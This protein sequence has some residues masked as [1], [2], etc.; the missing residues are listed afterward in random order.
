MQ[1]RRGSVGIGPR[2]ISHLANLG[3]EAERTGHQNHLSLF[4]TPD[5]TLEPTSFP[6]LKCEWCWNAQLARNQRFESNAFQVKKCPNAELSWVSLS[7]TLTRSLSH[8]LSHTLSLSLTHTHTLS[9]SLSHSRSGEERGV[10]EHGADRCGVCSNVY[11]HVYIRIDTVYTRIHTYIYVYIYLYIRIYTYIYGYKQTIRN[12]F[13]V[14][15][16][17][18]TSMEQIAPFPYDR[19]QVT[20]PPG[21][22]YSLLVHRI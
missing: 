6:F 1:P 15:N 10:D 16:V 5:S 11:I 12:G 18:V 21:R 22:G 20:S 9:L 4:E 14:K 13:Q 17:V 7:H 19:I 8:T 2:Q 3:A